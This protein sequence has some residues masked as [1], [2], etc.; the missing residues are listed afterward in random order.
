[1][2]GCLA[3]KVDDLTSGFPAKP[4]QHA[5]RMGRVSSIDALAAR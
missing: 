1:M 5:L 2:S 3:Q 4:G